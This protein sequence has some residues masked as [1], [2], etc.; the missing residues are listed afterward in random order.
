MTPSSIIREG[1]CGVPKPSTTTSWVRYLKVCVVLIVKRDSI[2]GKKPVLTNLEG[3]NAKTTNRT[4]AVVLSFK[5][6]VKNN[7]AE[8]GLFGQYIG[9]S[10]K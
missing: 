3:R 7:A 8:L 5:L 6:H 10:M 1:V 2:F 4:K 9:R